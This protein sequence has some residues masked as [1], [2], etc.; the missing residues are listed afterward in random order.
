MGTHP[1]VFSQT[2][3][4]ENSKNEDKETDEEGK[5]RGVSM[6]RSKSGTKKEVRTAYPYLMKIQ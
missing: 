2:L 6:E 4:Y 1:R 5:K 3:A